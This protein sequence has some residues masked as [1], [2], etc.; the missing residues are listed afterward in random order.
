MVVH[1]IAQAVRIAVRVV[2]IAARAVR[3]A[4]QA[5][6]IAARVA[7]I[8]AQVAGLPEEVSIQAGEAA[9]QEQ[10]L[11]LCRSFRRI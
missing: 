8:V 10:L 5:A 4:A 2:H 6:H 7:R 1:S 3:I 9:Q 11:F